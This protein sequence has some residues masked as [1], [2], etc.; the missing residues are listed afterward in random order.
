MRIRKRHENAALFSIPM[1][2][3]ANTGYNAGRAA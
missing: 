2:G 1:K 3:S